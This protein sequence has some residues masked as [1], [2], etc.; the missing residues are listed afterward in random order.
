[1][2][3]GTDMEIIRSIL[4]AQ[5]ELE[6]AHRNFEYADGELVDYYAYKIKSEQTKVD[7]LLKQAKDKNLVLTA[8]GARQ[9]Y[10]KIRLEEAENQI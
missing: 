1:M 3:I 10:H 4:R 9:E 7:Y 2:K 6:L 5:K 8:I